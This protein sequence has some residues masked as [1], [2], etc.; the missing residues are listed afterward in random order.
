MA[1]PAGDPLARPAVQ[2]D[3]RTG[4]TAAL[5][6][7]GVEPEVERDQ[8][9]LRIAEPLDE[10]REVHRAAQQ[11]GVVDDEPVC[12]AGDDPLEGARQSGPV[13]DAAVLAVAHDV[14]ELPAGAL[15]RTLD[16]TLGRLRS[17]PRAA[18]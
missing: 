18:R 13:E 17:V 3:Q 11:P 1:R 10:L 16:V 15:A 5:R 4:D 12:L 8:R 7:R 6:G 14:D 9:G 2:R